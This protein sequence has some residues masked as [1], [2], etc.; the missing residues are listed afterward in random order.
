MKKATLSRYDIDSQGRFIIDVASSRIEELYSNF[1]RTVP[2][3]K[4]DLDEYF[5]DY[6]IECVREIGSNSFIIRLDLEHL[7]DDLK[8]DRVIK[9]IRNY[10]IYLIECEKR[11]MKDMFRTSAV[12]FAGGVAIMVI[13]ILMRRAHFNST[14]VIVEVLSEGLTVAAWVAL[15]ESL[16]NLLIKLRPYLRNIRIYNKLA[17]AQV[18]FY[19]VHQDQSSDRAQSAVI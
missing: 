15:W 11:K 4:K 5:V 8:K 10:F 16:A 13:S 14:N 6:L 12:F 7:P 9:S 18:L 17:K 1:E 3:L 2:Y 19:K